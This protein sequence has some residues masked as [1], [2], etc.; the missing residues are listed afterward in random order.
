MYLSFSYFR[1][2]DS[3]GKYRKTSNTP[4]GDFSSALVRENI[5]LQPGR[6]EFVVTSK[7]S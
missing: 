6:T 2:T 7:V 1:R 3:H 5:I 4:K